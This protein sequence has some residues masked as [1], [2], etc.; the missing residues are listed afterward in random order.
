MRRYSPDQIEFF[1]AIAA[2]LILGGLW[3]PF[4]ARFVQGKG[5]WLEIPAASLPILVLV[6][7]VVYYQRRFRE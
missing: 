1:M 3:L 2:V 6:A 7:V 4:A 5:W